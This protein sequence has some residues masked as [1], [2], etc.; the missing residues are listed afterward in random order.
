LIMLELSSAGRHWF[1]YGQHL[2][3]W[4]IEEI[5]AKNIVADVAI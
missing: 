2:K 5:V 4:R 1:G 3:Y